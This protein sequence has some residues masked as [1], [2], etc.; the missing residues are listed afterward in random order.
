MWYGRIG[1]PADVSNNY[2]ASFGIDKKV[3]AGYLGTISDIAADD[4]GN[5]Y[6]I[7][8]DPPSYSNVYL[9]R[10]SDSGVNWETPIIIGDLG[11]GIPGQYWY[12]AAAVAVEGKNIYVSWSHHVGDDHWDIYL[13]RSTDY[14]KTFSEP[15]IVAKNTYKGSLS[16]V[17]VD[18]NLVYVGWIDQ[19]SG[20][21]NA[22]V[23]I[24]RDGGLTFSE[25]IRVDDGGSSQATMLDQ[26]LAACCGSVFATW[27]DTRN[28]PLDLYFSSAGTVIA[29]PTNT[30]PAIARII[31][32][33]ISDTSA[34]ITFTANQS[35][36]RTRVYYGTTESLGEFSS[37]NNNTGL[38][39]TI[40]LYNLS[41][42]TKYYY[43]IYA[44]NGSNQG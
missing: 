36:A 31:A 12:I 1:D 6:V 3:S 38:S 22:Y 2:G 33:N 41:G 28:D 30:A 7:F 14:G 37:W 42:S 13:K 21:L 34:N 40:A 15:V 20:D 29:A 39:I 11:S 35:D 17:A 27:Q 16:P 19:S 44:Y 9:T 25:P 23:A 5:V 26:S 24:S 8:T 10:S 4:S 43:S 18:G 32:V